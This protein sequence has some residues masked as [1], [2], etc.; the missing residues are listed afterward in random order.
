M[1]VFAIVLEYKSDNTGILHSYYNDVMDSVEAINDLI[2]D[3]Y[4]ILYNN[5]NS[6]DLSDLTYEKIIKELNGVIDL[7]YFWIWITVIDTK[8]AEKYF[9]EVLKEKDIKKLKKSIMK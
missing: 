1:K 6:I 4:Y 5:N 7:G 2:I 9:T 3:S 8:V